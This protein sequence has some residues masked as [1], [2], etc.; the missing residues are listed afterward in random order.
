[1]TWPAS[2]WILPEQLQFLQ[3]DLAPFLP[4]FD[5]PVE[6]R[7]GS[8]TYFVA[9]RSFE[10]FDADV[11]YALLRHARPRRMIELGSGFST[12]VAAGA[13]ECN[14]SDGA[15]CE[16]L[17]FDPYPRGNLPR[18]GPWDLAALPA[19]RV[20]QEVFDRLEGGDVLFVDTTHTVKM[21][22]D[23][24]RVVLDVLPRLAAGV[25]VHFHDIWLPWEYHRQ[26]VAE[27]GFWAEQYLLQAYLS[28]NPEWRVLLAAQALVR[29]YPKEY[30][31]RGSAP[32]RTRDASD[33]LLDPEVACVD[34]AQPRLAPGNEVFA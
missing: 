31:R 28:G 27:M 19:Q 12:L 14:A 15:P 20:P 10:S 26:L 7:W 30:A 16:H 23:V 6:G 18:S 25:I 22:G 24:N 11:L 9:N 13:L 5:P 3:R 8:G 4:E 32:R 34:T 17:V 2:G 21:G 1:M 29:D 33:E